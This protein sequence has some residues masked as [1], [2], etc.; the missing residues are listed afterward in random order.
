MTDYSEYHMWRPASAVPGGRWR[1]WKESNP[2]GSREY[3]TASGRIWYCF[4][5]EVAR[6]KA[7]EVNKREKRYPNGAPMFDS[8][9]MMLDDKGN[10]SIFDDV[11]K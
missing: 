2:A 6:R 5:H 3:R 11:D 8:S 7:D 4:S 10:R 1:L 9:G